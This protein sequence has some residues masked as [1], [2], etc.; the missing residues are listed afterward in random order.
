MKRYLSILLAAVTI[1]TLGCRKDNTK[2]NENKN[3]KAS[4]TMILTATA[5]PI[6]TVEVQPSKT[7]V[8]SSDVTADATKSPEPQGGE[9]LTQTATAEATPSLEPTPSA[10]IAEPTVAPSATQAVITSTPTEKPTAKP[11]VKPTIASKTTAPTSKPTAT[12][13][14]TVQPTVKPTATVKPT[15][16]PTIKPT[17]KPTQ[18]VAPTSVPMYRQDM[19]DEEKTA[20]FKYAAAETVKAINK[21]RNVQLI[22]LPGLTEYAEYRAKQLETNFA[23]DLG[24]QIE[25]STAL[26]YGRYIDPVEWGDVGE[27][28]Y[29][30]VAAE[31][32][33]KA[34]GAS[35][36]FWHSP[37]HWR[38]VGSDEYLYIGVGASK[39]GTCVCVA[40]TN[41]DILSE[42]NREAEK[43]DCEIMYYVNPDGTYCVWNENT[44]NYSKVYSSLEQW[45]DD[46][47][48]GNMFGLKK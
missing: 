45:Y 44:Q 2:D 26:K 20:Y 41:T 10:E 23:H 36:D 4:P 8:S 16:A 24:D 42:F 40:K 3:T 48:K 37:G 29:Q 47:K 31:A 13:Q 22:V 38:Y 33:C 39:G 15:E 11:T 18:T 21:R 12:V 14:P 19:T 30:P 9:D 34:L 28:Y 43:K 5:T 7:P 27:P 6:P 17:V 1:F 35:A 32:I 25:A 46:W